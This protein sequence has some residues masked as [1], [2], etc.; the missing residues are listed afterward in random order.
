MARSKYSVSSL[1]LSFDEKNTHPGIRLDLYLEG[2][3]K[4]A[5]L[6]PIK[7]QKKSTDLLTMP[8]SNCKPYIHFTIK[9]QKTG[10]SITKSGTVERYL[11]EENRSLLRRM[12]SYTQ[13]Y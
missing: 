2:L 13:R 10:Q 6:R 11:K 4:L 9:N 1:Q 5:G 7:S 12:I 3:Y 8:W